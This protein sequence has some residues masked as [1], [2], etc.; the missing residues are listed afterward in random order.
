MPPGFGQTPVAQ[1][2]FEA[3]VHL[4]FIPLRL[5]QFLRSRAVAGFDARFRLGTV[6]IFFLFRLPDG[7]AVSFMTN[8]TG[9]F[10]STVWPVRVRLALRYGICLPSFWKASSESCRSPARTGAEHFFE[11]VAAHLVVGAQLTIQLAG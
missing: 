4:G 8:A 5:C 2:R 7:G 11:C 10:S 3:D 9:V 6:G 1:R